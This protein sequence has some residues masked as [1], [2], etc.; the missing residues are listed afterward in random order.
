LSPSKTTRK[1]ANHLLTVERLPKRHLVPAWLTNNAELEHTLGWRVARSLL[2]APVARLRQNWARDFW[3]TR[4]PRAYARITQLESA[5]GVWGTTSPHFSGRFQRVDLSRTGASL[6]REPVVI[7][8]VGYDVSTPQDLPLLHYQKSKGKRVL[9]LLAGGIGDLIL[10]AQFFR[11]L[12]AQQGCEVDV[13]H[14]RATYDSRFLASLFAPSRVLE[15]PVK[16][17]VFAKYDYCL[18]TSAHGVIY[19]ETLPE[20]FARA[21]GVRFTASGFDV[22][23]PTARAVRRR[24]EIRHGIPLSAASKDAPIVIHAACRHE[25]NYPHF[26][27]VA[28]ALIERGHRVIV[29]GALHESALPDIPGQLANLCGLDVWST[30]VAMRTAK[31][32]IGADSAFMHAA[33][34]WNTPSL[35]LFGPT[36]A[37][38]ATPYPD[39]T[40]VTLPLSCRFAP[41][42]IVLSSS[43]PCATPVNP[44]C[45][46]Q[47]APADIVALAERKLNG[48]RLPKI[49]PLR[50]VPHDRVTVDRRV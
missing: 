45:L 34:A 39:T 23:D 10:Y 49:W 38:W 1:R 6:P 32:F 15:F 37:F 4:S 18:P 25:K 19:G 47:I 30:I 27:A 16:A 2:A 43:R 50:R 33:G 13:A 26:E 28:S 21:F 40:V 14:Q 9:A 48:Q 3:N 41:C 35:A 31:L 42:W 12:R 11:A 7:P 24:V 36:P 8:R 29:V 46:S 44:P 5:L 17:E 20:Y 22:D